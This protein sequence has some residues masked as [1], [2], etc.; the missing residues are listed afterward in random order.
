M[1]TYADDTP[2]ILIVTQLVHLKR[3][4]Y[5]GVAEILHAKFSLADFAF[6]KISQNK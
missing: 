5:S 3:K 6:N 2:L 4:L 1:F